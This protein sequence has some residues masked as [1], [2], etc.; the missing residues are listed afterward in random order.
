MSILSAEGGIFDLMAGRYSNGIPNLGSLFL[1]G[2]S[3]E[4]RS[5][6]IVE[7]GKASLL[8]IQP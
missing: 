1:Q 8:N 2:H 7:A 4:I 3:V 6:L 5:G